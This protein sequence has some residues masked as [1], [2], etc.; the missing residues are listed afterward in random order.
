MGVLVFALSLI[1]VDTPFWS[2]LV[3]AI[4][5]IV[6]NVPE[7]MLTTVTLCLSIAARRMAGQ[8]ALIRNLQS[9]ETL[10][11]TTVICTDKTGTLTANRMSLQRLFLNECIHSEADTAFEKEELE[12]FLRVAVLCNNARI[13]T[14]GSSGRRSDRDGAA[15]LCA[16]FSRSCSPCGLPLPASLKNRSPPPP[17]RW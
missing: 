4:G 6:A 11:C 14:D 13:A 15:R 16:A 3:F 1:W 9:V 12:E 10:G 7:G 5:I 8:N 2:K 17:R